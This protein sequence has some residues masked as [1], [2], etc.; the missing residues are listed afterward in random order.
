MKWLKSSKEIIILAFATV[1]IIIAAIVDFTDLIC[2][3]N[4]FAIKFSNLDDLIQSVY[5]IQASIATLGIAL[6][7]LL[8][9]SSK[10][11]AFG[12]SVSKY[13]M[14]DRPLI[15]KY[16]TSIITELIFIILGYV[17][18][19]FN[20]LNLFI[21]IFFISTLIIIFMT[22]DIFKVFLG[23]QHIK[24][25]M[26]NFYVDKYAKYINLPKRNQ[27][28]NILKS[29]CDDTKNAILTDNSLKFNENFNMLKMLFTNTVTNSNQ[30]IVNEVENYFSDILNYT[31]KEG[32]ENQIYEVL[33]FIK[34]TYEECNNNNK[35]N[36]SNKIY[37]NL[38]DN[39]YR[40]FFKSL[41]KVRLEKFEEEY[42][43][44]FIQQELYNNISF[45]KNENNQLNCFS[46]RDYSSLVY[47]YAF[48]YN[49]FSLDKGKNLRFKKKIFEDTLNIIKYYNNNYKRLINIA[50][51]DLTL[52]IRNLILN[53]DFEILTKT[54]IDKMLYRLNIYDNKYIF[55]III[56]LY[57]LAY[58]ETLKENVYSDFAKRFIENNKNSLAFFLE[59]YEDY[60]YL[61]VD[62]IKNIKDNLST[63]EITPEGKSKLLIIDDVVT[64]FFVFYILKN[65]ENYDMLKNQLK[66]TIGNQAF[67]YNADYNQEENLKRFIQLINNQAI[68][69]FNKYVDDEQEVENKRKFIQFL[70][71]FY[72]M[73]KNE[74]KELIEN[75]KL[76]ISFDKLKS[77]IIS[78]CKEPILEES[79]KYKNNNYD[80]YKKE[81]KNKLID[82]LND[83]LRL[84]NVEC[85]D[86]KKENQYLITINTEAS[87]LNLVSISHELNYIKESFMR[88]LIDILLTKSI[89]LNVN[90][91]VD[92]ILQL[93]FSQLDKSSLNV[94]TLVGYRNWFYKE[95]KKDIQR[96]KELEDKMN[97]IQGNSCHNIILAVDSTTIYVSLKDVKISIEKYK[98][99]EVLEKVNRKENEID[100][101]NY[102]VT[103]D[104]FLPF[105][106][107]ELLEY[108]DNQKIKLIVDVKLE[109]G[110]NKECVGSAVIIDYDND[111]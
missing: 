98:E 71:I 49:E 83:K 35:A 26:M 59:Y 69:Y 48:K 73:E 17:F 80:E 37:L 78:I 81:F 70:Q 28:F 16:S 7:A 42:I 96:F 84:F 92:E 15:F 57:Y 31:L 94:D 27:S 108:F 75:E 79:K 38:F 89:K 55:S 77:A 109:Y 62:Y 72:D 95:D 111:K 66:L 43:L 100:I 86:T 32:S 82:D 63:W 61:N 22:K 74:N 36:Q 4:F 1:Y 85:K 99:E 97:K 5:Q 29:L 44:T 51:D 93:F 41:S 65:C 9:E 19:A 91:S 11:I 67:S 102:R 103:N 18:I 87:S 88:L 56:Y 8:S 47:D 60:S 53:K 2:I 105:E 21:S 12:I 110:F 14:Q 6:I 3:P 13:I 10:E 68:Y 33:K 64:D 106:K 39:V 46:L 34:Q 90:N 23:T 104:I 54:F 40:T 25:E 20:W 52:F 45:S 30:E 107:A 58:F 50:Y 24:N 101:F 76:Q